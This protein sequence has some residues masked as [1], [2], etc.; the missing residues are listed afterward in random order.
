MM[1]ETT[2]PAFV[3]ISEE[4]P[5]EGFQSEPATIP[6]ADKVKLIEALA[7]TGLAEINCCSFVNAAQVPQMADAE[8]IVA[9]LHRRPGVR[10]TGLWLNVKGF[11]RAQACGIDLNPTLVTSASE[12]FG[13][14]N[15]K[16]NR[17]ELLD[18][19]RVMAKAYK[20]AGLTSARGYVFTAFGCNYEGDIPVAQVVA[21]VQDLLTL[22]EEVGIDLEAMYLCDTIGSASPRTVAGAIDGVRMRWP[23]L[24]VALHLHDTRGLGLT[25][26]HVGL[27]MGVRRFDSSVA[28]LGGCPFAGNAAAAGNISTEDLVYLCEEEG[29]ETGIDLDRL[30]D[31]AL[32]AERIV[33]RTL[34]GRIKHARAF[35]RNPTSPAAN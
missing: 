27:N 23:D 33:G 14:R 10:Y 34:P 28:G 8:E 15:N 6:T 16:R 18:G 29:F 20:A 1:G 32:L 25:N 11:E 17:A 4:G 35:R 12:T 21:S 2:N 19:Q 24:E 9:S 30:I 3:R 22:G 5:R 26:A 13:L 7:E 31:C